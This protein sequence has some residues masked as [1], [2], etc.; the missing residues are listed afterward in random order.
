M[1]SIR[2][3]FHKNVKKLPYNLGFSLKYDSHNH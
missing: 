1:I 2:K 3:F